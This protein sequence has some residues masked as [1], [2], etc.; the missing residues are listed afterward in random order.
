M[1]SPF[2]E[3]NRLKFQNPIV[4]ILPLRINSTISVFGALLLDLEWDIV[5]VVPLPRMP[6]TT[7]MKIFIFSFGDPNLN[8][9]LPLGQ[10][11]IQ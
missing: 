4:S 7:R 1:D 11:K 3:A 10:P 8:L 6:V 5:W 2:D 9:H